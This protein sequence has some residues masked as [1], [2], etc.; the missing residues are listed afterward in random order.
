MQN[1]EAGRGL[2]TLGKSFPDGK[3]QKQKQKMKVSKKKEE[4]TNQWR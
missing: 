1:T 2:Q 4:F 3:K